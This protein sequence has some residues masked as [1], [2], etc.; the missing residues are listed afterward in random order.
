MYR[1]AHSRARLI[2]NH[3]QLRNSSSS[4]TTP[5][6]PASESRTYLHQIRILTETYRSLLP[7]RPYLPPPES[8]LPALLAHRLTSGCVAETAARHATA[9]AEH[10]ALQVR[11]DAER[12]DL[13][14]ARA[15]QSALE[16]RIAHL[17]TSVAS[18][19][20]RSSSQVAKD[21]IRNLE[22]KK[23]RYDTD[24]GQL[25][26]AF[27]DFVVKQLA[28]MLAAEELGGPIAG[29]VQEISEDVLQTG[30]GSKGKAR[31]ANTAKAKDEERSRQKRI[32]DIWG[33]KP[34]EQRDESRMDVDEDEDDDDEWDEK[35]AAAEE[36]KEL[37]ESLLNALMGAQ[38]GSGESAYVNL[39]RDSAA[40]RFLVRSKIAQFHPRDARR[41]RLL[42]FAGEIEY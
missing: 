35:T 42:D 17:Q 24:T 40:S 37:T 15:I 32:T 27:N 34:N 18:Q 2:A 4:S 41:L 8:P 21:M 36:M 19:S 1:H 31:K 10:A 20:C 39:Q 3:H 28:P 26:R 11:L 12:A 29:D 30:F 22:T 13:A 16:R 38:H 9:T 7:A 6:L 23:S 25:L 14:D 5:V 33:P